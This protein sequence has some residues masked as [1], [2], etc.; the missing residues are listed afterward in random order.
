MA[1][2]SFSFF[3]FSSQEFPED[4][5]IDGPFPQERPVD[6]VDV[7]HDPGHDIFAGFTYNP[8]S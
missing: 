7:G 6:Q 4:E 5:G 1:F 3:L 2:E 8:S